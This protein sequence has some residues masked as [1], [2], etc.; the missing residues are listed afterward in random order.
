MNDKAQI[1]STYILQK[2]I[3]QI[4]NRLFGVV[5]GKIDAF[6]SQLTVGVLDGL[7]IAIVLER[8]RPMLFLS[9]IITNCPNNTS[10]ESNFF[11]YLNEI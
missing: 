5:D 7:E 11:A 2:R 6:T 9:N 4:S 10:I 8:R 3:G 1:N